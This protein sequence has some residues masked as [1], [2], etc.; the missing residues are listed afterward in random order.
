MKSYNLHKSSLAVFLF[1][2][3]LSGC[4]GVAEQFKKNYK[5]S[6][7][8][9]YAP[10]KLGTDTKNTGLMLVDAI[11]KVTFNNMPISGASIINISDPEKIITV[12]SFKTGGVF[13]QQ[14]GVVVIPNLKPGIYRIV[15]IKTQNINMWETL[16][17]PI[18][19]EYEVEILAGKPTYFGRI[20]VKHPIGTTDRIIKLNHEPS[21]E[22]ESWKLVIEKY[23]E[24]PWVNIINSHINELK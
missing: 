12:G 2:A 1:I 3:L 13:S 23:K 19:K 20:E 6:T 7:E 11:K 5:E 24:S 8:S 9:Y 21:R 22:A 14:S 17:M 16:Y 15:K 10:E 4:A 18:T